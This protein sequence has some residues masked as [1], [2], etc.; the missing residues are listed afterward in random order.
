MGTLPEGWA[1][2]AN[3]L[4]AGRLQALRAKRDRDCASRMP[5]ALHFAMRRAE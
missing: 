3:R 4:Q 5:R 2:G 1:R